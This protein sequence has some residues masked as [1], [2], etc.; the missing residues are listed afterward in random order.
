MR[1]MKDAIADIADRN[2]VMERLMREMAKK[3]NKPSDDDER[4]FI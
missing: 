3:Q 4:S 1:K 2:I